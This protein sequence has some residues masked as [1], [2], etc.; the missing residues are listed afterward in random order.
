MR[1][2]TYAMIHIGTDGYAYAEAGRTVSADQ[3]SDRKAVY[4]VGRDGEKAISDEEACESL[5]EEQK[6]MQ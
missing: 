6:T 5:T 1:T 4:P 2:G 3:V